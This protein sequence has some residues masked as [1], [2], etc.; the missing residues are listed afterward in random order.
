M[1]SL[2]GFTIG[3][4]AQFLALSITEQVVSTIAG[5]LLLVTA[6]VQI[7][8]HRSFIP[9]RILQPYT[10]HLSKLMKLLRGKRG[11]HIHGMLGAING[12]LPC[13]LVTSALF[14]AAAT[15]EPLQAASFMAVFGLG[16]VPAM[17]ATAFVSRLVA[18]KSRQYFRIASPF[19]TALVGCILVVRGMGLG[20]PYI[21]PAQT[22]HVHDNTCCR[23]VH[24]SSHLKP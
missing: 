14:G 5:S 17:A 1:Y 4:G 15:T 16:T 2:L 21:S 24:T 3:V 9:E 18:G 7:L 11:L 23:P 6:I 22:A 12:L 8:F 20:I 19:A 13:G 10:S